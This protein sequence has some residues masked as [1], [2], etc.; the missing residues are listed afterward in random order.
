METRD[1][2]IQHE[3]FAAAYQRV[4]SKFR[5]QA[6]KEGAV[7]LPNPR[8]FGPVDVVFVAMEPSLGGWAG[9]SPDTGRKLVEHTT[10]VDSY[11][12][13]STRKCQNVQSWTTK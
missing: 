10:E 3:S 11:S 6:E 13:E 4:E 2:E 1:Q 5:S 7:Y 9:G 8:P 12:K